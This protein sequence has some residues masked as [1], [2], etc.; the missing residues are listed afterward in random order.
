MSYFNEST[1]IYRH[2][3]WLYTAKELGSSD[4]LEQIAHGYG[5][6]YGLGT[7]TN[8]RSVVQLVGVRT[9]NASLT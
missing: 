2:V 3:C 4:F 8:G 9:K 5:R 7:G 1:H 6:S